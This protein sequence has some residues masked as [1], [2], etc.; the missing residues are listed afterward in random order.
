MNLKSAADSGKRAALWFG[1]SA[2]AARGFARA[3]A[4]PL[5]LLLL[6][7]SEAGTQA[8]RPT[9][10]DQDQEAFRI[11]VDVSLVVL[12]ASVTDRRGG[13]VSSLEE[14]DFAVYEDGV[15]QHLKFF[16]GEDVPVTVGL[17]VDHST[18]MQPRLADVIAA[19]RTFVRSS[20]RDDEMFVVNFNERVTL[21]LPAA[22]RF[23][24]STAELESAIM[25]TPPRGQTAL[26]D[27]IAKALDELQAG[28]RDKKILIVVSDG[29][30]NAS[31]R[32]L[33]QVLKLAEQSS[34]I[35][36][37]VGIFNDDDPDKNPGV[38]QHLAR[39][40]GGEA[41]LPKEPGE[42]VASCE[43]IAHDIRHQYTL[44]YVPLRLTQAGE[45]HSIRVVAQANGHDHLSVR[46]R[47]GYTAASLPAVRE[48][49]GK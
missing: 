43:R 49:S 16:T 33:P 29:G 34:A 28:S 4:V 38:L 45:H 35:I 6:L 20:N 12:H 37:T 32:K 44:G 41:F 24:N 25:R 46:A 27:A 21:G 47:T 19:A 5:A 31:T 26:Y 3:I 39:S 48:E 7:A 22:L 11:S 1:L 8:S 18:T 40:T 42:V 15:L 30:D 9:I 2:A 23:T 36:Y 17:V 14:K 13:F 10:P